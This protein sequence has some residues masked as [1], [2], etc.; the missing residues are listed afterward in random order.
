MTKSKGF[1]L[2][3]VV[4]IMIFTSII[5]AITVGI[6]ITN[7]SKM[8]SNNYNELLNDENITEFLN[9]YNSILDNY[10][11]DVDKTAMVESAINAMLNY[12]DDNY[13]TYMSPEQK[14]ELAERL[15]GT[16]MGIG[17]TVQRCKIIEVTKGSPA[18]EAGLMVDDVIIKINDEDFSTCDD[19]TNYLM[20]NAIKKNENKSINI[21]VKRNEEEKTFQ[22][23]VKELIY[24]LV[25]SNM[26]DDT[27]IGYIG[28][29][30]FSTNIT[31]QFTTAYNALKEQGLEKLIIDLRGNTGGYLEGARGIA[32]LFIEKGKELFTLEGKDNKETFY[33]ED[34]TAEKIPIVVLINGGSASA[35]EIL[36]GALK[37]SYGATLVGTTSFGK[38]KVQQTYTLDDGSMAKYTTAL[39][40]RPN[41]ECIDGIGIQPDI[42]VVNEETT[43]ENGQTVIID[44]SLPKAIEYLNTVN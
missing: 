42:E 9:V 3:A 13:T 27:K 8:N 17:V 29:S 32:S 12:L 33:D 43:D 10:Y 4:L 6:I 23:N 25:T 18:E 21:T 39:W 41:G 35:S 36:T 37:D 22:V 40:Y 31:E 26:I 2:L 30:I 11:E 5:S 24:P 14:Q 19:N 20:V 15:S 34:D 44:N 1:N 28:F 38:G 16:Y 7:S